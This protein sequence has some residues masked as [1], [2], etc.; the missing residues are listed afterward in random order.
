MTHYHVIA[1][2]DVDIAISSVVYDSYEDSVEAWVRLSTALFSEYKDQL[3][4]LEIE[5][6]KAATKDGKGF[7]A[8]VGTSSLCF[9]WMKCDHRCYSITWN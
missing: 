4:G 2:R 9:Y 5:K 7:M 8:R 3:G 1:A 6:A